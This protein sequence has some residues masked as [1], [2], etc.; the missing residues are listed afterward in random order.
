M[1]PESA[2]VMAHALQGS[3]RRSTRSTSSIL[4]PSG[5]RT[6]PMRP[7]PVPAGFGV[8]GSAGTPVAKWREGLID[9]V[10]AQR[11]M[12]EIGSVGVGCR[13]VEQLQQS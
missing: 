12:A 7:M 11:E 8:P 10:H 3:S 13:A 6:M 4:T 9:V 2:P 1:Q 5:S